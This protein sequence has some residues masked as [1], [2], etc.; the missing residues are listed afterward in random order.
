MKFYN[1]RKMLSGLMASSTYAFFVIRYL[2]I[3]MFKWVWLQGA[4]HKGGTNGARSAYNNNGIVEDRNKHKNALDKSGRSNAMSIK[5]L[6]GPNNSDN[7]LPFDSGS[8]KKNQ[9]VVVTSRLES[10]G[11]ERMTTSKRSVPNMED[12]SFEENAHNARTIVNNGE[13]YVN[14][15]EVVN[16]RP[17]SDKRRR[18]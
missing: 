4:M 16:K 8:L 15:R 1:L 9:V 17:P 3:E 14:G 18:I 10:D 2:D 13:D 11:A 7:S 5:R 12:H 6:I